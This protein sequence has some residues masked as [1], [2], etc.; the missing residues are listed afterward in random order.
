[1]TAPRGTLDYQDDIPPLG[2]AKMEVGAAHPCGGAFSLMPL[3]SLAGAIRCRRTRNHYYFTKTMMVI[4]FRGGFPDDKDAE[5]S[6]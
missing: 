6:L 2:S 1:M 3:S 4:E 5:S